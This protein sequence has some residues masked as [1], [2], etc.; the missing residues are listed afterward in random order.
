MRCIKN[1]T[2][3][4]AKR[5]ISANGIDNRSP[6]LQHWH[7]L[8]SLL[9]QLTVVFSLKLV[10]TMSLLSRSIFR[11]PISRAS[12]RPITVLS[13]RSFHFTTSRFALNET[14]RS[15]RVSSA[16][17]V[18]RF[19]LGG[20]SKSLFPLQYIYIYIYIYIS[21][22]LWLRDVLILGVGGGRSRRGCSERDR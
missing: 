10:S 12:I 7:C 20:V 15:K 19:L 1:Q 11:T 8:N 21:F 3:T 18:V 22:S 5:T 16:L 13:S 9:L 2:M 6:S 14:D 17:F 4:S